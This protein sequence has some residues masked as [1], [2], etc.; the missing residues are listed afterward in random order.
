MTRDFDEAVAKLRARRLA[1]KASLADARARLSP[2]QLAEDALSLVD[3]ELALLGRFKARIE[4]NRLLSLAVL[5]GTGWLVGSPRQH[6]GETLGAGEAGT[7]PPRVNMKEKN[8]DSGQ[9]HGEHWSGPGA[10]RAEIGRPEKREEA[11]VITRRRRKAKQV[12]GRAPLG[13]QPERPAGERQQVAEPEQPADAE[14]QQQPEI[15]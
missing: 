1:L 14:R 5:A 11:P 6:H 15:R 13:R 7:P 2:P 8:N 9:I 3:P 10:G 12:S 4:G